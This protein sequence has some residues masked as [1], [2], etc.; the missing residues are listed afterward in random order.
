M[1]GAAESARSALPAPEGTE[2]AAARDEEARKLREEVASLQKAVEAST[3]LASQ[4][5]SELNSE[6]MKSERALVSNR[7]VL[8]KL[9]W[10]SLYLGLLPALLSVNFP[11]VVFYHCARLIAPSLSSAQSSACRF[12]KS[13]V[14]SFEVG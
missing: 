7:A 12:D 3:V 4:R 11:H 5:E 9:S 2:S 8:Q 6:R 14:H 1:N 10:I 13:Q